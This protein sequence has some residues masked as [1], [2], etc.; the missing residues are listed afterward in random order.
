MTSRLREHL[1]NLR[2]RAIQR[3]GAIIFD[4]LPLLIAL[5]PLIDD[6]GVRSAIEHAVDDGHGAPE[7]LDGSNARQ[8]ARLETAILEA[9][10]GVVV[11]EL[12]TVEARLGFGWFEAAIVLV[13]TPQGTIVGYHTMDDAPSF[14]M[15]AAGERDE[16][17]AMLAD[18]PETILPRVLHEHDEVVRVALRRA[19]PW[20]LEQV[21]AVVEAMAGTV[22]PDRILRQDILRDA[23]VR[24]P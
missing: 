13:A 22:T 24:V 8:A 11:E 5:L 21:V 20:T 15:V 3:G 18:R 4:P 17:L 1:L 7:D 16:L 19:A 9:G 12:L 23:A 6:E 10:E 2:R 14:H